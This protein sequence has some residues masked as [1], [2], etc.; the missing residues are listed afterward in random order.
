LVEFLIQKLFRLEGELRK[1][2]KSKKQKI[3]ELADVYE[4]GLQENHVEILKRMRNVLHK[5]NLERHDICNALG[6][7]CESEDIAEDSYVYKILPKRLKGEYSRHV[8]NVTTL[9]AEA[10]SSTEMWSEEKKEA[11]FDTIRDDVENIKNRRKPVIDKPKLTGNK[12][13]ILTLL[14][15]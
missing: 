1:L 14:F 12:D 15:F 8:E 3:L 9:E 2:T 5:D 11:I 4:Q 7:W 6:K 10:V 13:E